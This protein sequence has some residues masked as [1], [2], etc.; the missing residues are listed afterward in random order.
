MMK[1]VVV[2][3]FHQETGRFQEWFNKMF[4][5]QFCDEYF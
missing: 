4:I 5:A 3:V 1:V 2:T